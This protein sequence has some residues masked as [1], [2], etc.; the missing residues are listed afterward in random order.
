MR[1]AISSESNLLPEAGSQRM[2]I[3]STSLVQYYYKTA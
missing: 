1:C 2:I 3:N